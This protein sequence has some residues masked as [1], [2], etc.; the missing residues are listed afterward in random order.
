M[1]HIVHMLYYAKPHHILKYQHC[2][3]LLSHGIICDFNFLPFHYSLGVWS[4]M[5]LNFLEQIQVGTEHKFC[6]LA[7]P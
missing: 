3:S 2:V 4:C 6:V 1:S 7:T 5:R